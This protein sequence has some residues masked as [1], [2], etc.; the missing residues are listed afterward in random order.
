MRCWSPDGGDVI[1]AGPAGLGG[2]GAVRRGAE[3]LPVC[4]AGKRAVDILPR[5]RKLNLRARPWSSIHNRAD[6]LP[7][8]SWEKGRPPQ[9]IARR[10]F[11]EPHVGRFSAA[12][13]RATRNVVGY[14]THVAMLLRAAGRRT[15]GATFRT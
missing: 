5:Y 1:A 13:A 7:S 10:R 2:V 8:D 11:S 6:W 9:G 4:K 3:E 14:A 12:L 15:C